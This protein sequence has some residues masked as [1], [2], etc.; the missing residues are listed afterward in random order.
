MFTPALHTTHRYQSL[1][2]A[3]ADPH[4][5]HKKNISAQS[6]DLFFTLVP[7]QIDFR[8]S[9]CATNERKFAFIPFKVQ[10]LACDRWKTPSQS[11]ALKDNLVHEPVPQ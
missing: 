5:Q 8:S 11:T 7:L 3:D 10:E 4:I 2:R 6:V 9:L 1:I